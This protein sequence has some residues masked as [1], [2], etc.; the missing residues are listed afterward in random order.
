MK[1]LFNFI[2][3]LRYLM[4]YN[5]KE[6]YKDTLYTKYAL[7]FIKYEIKDELDNLFIPKI[8]SNEETINYIIQNNASISRFGDGEFILIN[9]GSIGF[10]KANKKLSERLTEILLSNDQN[11]CIAIPY[12]MCH[13]TNSSNDFEK[14]FTRTFWGANINWIIKLLKKDKLYFSPGFTIL[15]ESIDKYHHIRQIWKNKDIT[16]ISGD[17][18]F[19]KVKFNVFDN[20]KSIEYINAPT[21]NA[22]ERYDKILAQAVKIPKDRLICIILRP[23]ATVL[24]YDLA[25]LGYQ[26]LDL[27]HIVKSYDAFC[28]K[29]ELTPSYLN[30]FFAKD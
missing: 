8:L 22:F 16:V 19:K 15:P 13:T 26:A 27:G 17:R 23:T 21:V 25:K 10:Q 6:I 24:A 12:G 1:A 29:D 7:D 4:R 20:A 28:K 18:V 2:N 9:N 11:I 3:N 5:I 14:Y 30:K